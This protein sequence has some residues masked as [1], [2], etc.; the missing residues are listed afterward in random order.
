MW[1]R[2]TLPN[3]TDRSSVLQFFDRETC[4]RGWILAGSD[5]LTTDDGGRSW[6]PQGR[7]PF[8]N[9]SKWTLGYLSLLKGSRAGWA[10]GSLATIEDN[11]DIDSEETMFR[12]PDSGFLWVRQSGPATDDVELMVKALSPTQAVAADRQR[13][14]RTTAN[15]NAWVVTAR[16]PEELNA[17]EASQ[18]PNPAPCGNPAQFYFLDSIHGWLTYE[19]S[20]LLET[21]DGGRHWR[22]R[23]RT[24]ELWEGSPGLTESG[25]I[26][27]ESAS[28]GWIL[29]R[30][31]QIHETLDAG[32][33]W[34]VVPADDLILGLYCRSFAEAGFRCW[35]SGGNHLWQLSPASARPVMH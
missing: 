31:C 6:S 24:G 17:G 1:R 30:D 25:T 10:S 33:S 5:I 22:L 4:R 9:P 8:D 35:A 23:A 13:L 15:G 29:G 34:H 12:T 18:A 19:D 14:Y 27:F 3:N 20:C 32:E 21:L 11:S 7:L 2:L 28:T 16:L 26:F